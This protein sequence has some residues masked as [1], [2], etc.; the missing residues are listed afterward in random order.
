MT[1]AT[2]EVGDLES[3]RMTVDKLVSFLELDLVGRFVAHLD[4][5]LKRGATLSLDD[6]FTMLSFVNKYA[7]TI[8]AN[9]NHTTTD[10]KVFHLVIGVLFLAT[11]R[12]NT[13]YCDGHERFV[14]RKDRNLTT[15]SWQDYLVDLFIHFFAR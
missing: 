9:F 15:T 7:D 2:V 3:H 6:I 13:R 11:H 4:G 1:S 14:M 10:G 8:S 12:D 5:A